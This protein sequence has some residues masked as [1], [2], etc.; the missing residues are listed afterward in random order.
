M[1]T[2][3]EMLEFTRQSMINR[4][5]NAKNGWNA[6]IPGLKHTNTTIK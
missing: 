3:R 6:P 5:P 1:G 2:A 4:D